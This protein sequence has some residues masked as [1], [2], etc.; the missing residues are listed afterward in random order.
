MIGGRVLR[1]LYYPVVVGGAVALNWGATASG[2]VH[3]DALPLLNLAISLLCIA[4]L[5]LSE[6]ALPYHKDWLVGRGDFFADCAQSLVVLPLLVKLAQV[7][8]AH[9][10]ALVPRVD[11]VDLSALPLALQ[12]VAALVVAELLFYAMHRAA[13][14]W[15]PWWRLHRVHHGA[16][17]VYWGNAGRFHA[18]DIALQFPI[19]FAPLFLFGLTPQAFSLFLTLNSVT[20]LL[21]HANVDFTAGPLNFVFNSAE[22]HR[23]HHAQELALANSNYGKVLCIWDLVFRTHHIERTFTGPVGADRPVP[24]TLLAQ[25]ADPFRVAV[26][27]VALV[28]VGAACATVPLPSSASAPGAQAT[29]A[30][31]VRGR[32]ALPHCVVASDGRA[33]TFAWDQADRYQRTISARVDDR[34]DGGG[35]RYDF[36]RGG[37]DIFG[38]ALPDDVVDALEQARMGADE[39]RP[40]RVSAEALSQTAYSLPENQWLTQRYGHGFA[41]SVYA[42][43]LQAQPDNQR[44][45]RELERL[46]DGVLAQ[47]DDSAVLELK[48]RAPNVVVLV[49]MGFG[50]D[51]DVDENTKDYVKAFLESVRTLGIPVDVLHHATWGGLEENAAV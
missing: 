28:V 42:A 19:Y 9:A 46:V 51:P 41:A 34:C 38:I 20:G 31:V 32:G 45:R 12:V 14:A 11:V 5:W 29:V 40:A 33:V 48:K 6:R 10:F 2:L 30:R 35:A 43:W 37:H 26:L 47:S 25:F 13:H 39:L 17:R 24:V 36:P 16:P 3:D 1:G 23:R 49:S 27:V 4:V 18:L 21:E 7:L 15:P 50:W 22:L 8:D 44:A